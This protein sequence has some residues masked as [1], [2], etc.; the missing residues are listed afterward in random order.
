MIQQVNARSHE[1]RQ[2]FN[3][4]FGIGL[5]EGDRERRCADWSRRSE[6]A[7]LG[8]NGGQAKEA[9]VQASKCGKGGNPCMELAVHRVAGR[10]TGLCDLMGARKSAGMSLVPWWI[11]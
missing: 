11:S 10:R 2:R 6:R 3:R 5:E 8:N 9:R 7:E 1:V 4:G